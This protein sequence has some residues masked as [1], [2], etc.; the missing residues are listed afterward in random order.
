MRQS[1]CSDALVSIWM[2]TAGAKPT[3]AHQAKPL[4]SK[5]AKVRSTPISGQSARLPVKYFN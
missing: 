4:I 1:R 3:S 2:T 5:A